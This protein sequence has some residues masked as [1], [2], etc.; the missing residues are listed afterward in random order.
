MNAPHL[1]EVEL[2][3]LFPGVRQAL[4]DNPDEAE[5][6]AAEIRCHIGSLCIPWGDIKSVRVLPLSL[7]EAEA[8]RVAA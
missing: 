3:P 6:A 4:F 7:E 5:Q 8:W 1:V 2:G